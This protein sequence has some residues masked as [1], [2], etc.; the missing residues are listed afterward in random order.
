MGQHP[1][2][3]AAWQNTAGKMGSG[4][5]GTRNISGNQQPAG[6]A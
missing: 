4:A 6:R 3:I 5:G 1:D 2:V